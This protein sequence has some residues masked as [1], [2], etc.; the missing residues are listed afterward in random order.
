VVF[1]ESAYQYFSANPIEFWGFVTSV[2]CVWLN[3]RENIW[4][5][6][7]AIVAAG[8]YCKVFYD[9]RLYGD[10]LLQIVFAIMSAYGWYAWLYGGEQ[11]T[12]LII[13]KTPTV[14]YQP[15]LLVFLGGFTGIVCL[16]Y[17]LN[18]DLIWIDAFLTALS[19]LA[20]WMMTRKYLENWLI[21]TVANVLYV[22]VYFY[23]GVYLTAF[24]YIIF[25]F[26]AVS[27]YWSWN[28]K[29]TQENLTNS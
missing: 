1:I 27:G 22:G 10:M 25:L 9:I 13:T 26:L 7:F 20:Q 21:W 8:L 18:S 5:W 17:S 14:L 4:G 11:K 3:T 6:A 28:K 19:L 12:A 2:L 29:M 16:L 15:I 23:K 24:L